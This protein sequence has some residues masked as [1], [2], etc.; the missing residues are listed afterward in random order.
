[1]NAWSPISLGASLPG[2]SP[3]SWQEVAPSK[4]LG[5]IKAH[6]RPAIGHDATSV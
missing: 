5:N 4:F 3:L 6:I 2:L 1:M